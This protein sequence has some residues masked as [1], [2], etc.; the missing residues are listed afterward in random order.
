MVALDPRVPLVLL[1]CL[2]CL[3]LAVD[4][5]A[6][7]AGLAGVGVVALAGAGRG[8]P[9]LRVAAAL[10]ALVWS[11]ALS[12]GLFYGDLPRVVW[13]QLGPIVLWREG[14]VHGL[15][16]S[17][18]FVALTTAGAAVAV[19]VPP[20]R[21][22][23]GLRALRVPG[24]LAL[25]VAAAL[26]FVPQV[27]RELWWVRASRASRGRA[28]WRRWPHQWLLLELELLVPVVARSWRR[29]AALA[30]SLDSRGY[31]P[32]VARASWRPLRMRPGE[33]ALVVGAVAGT[34]VVCGVRALFWA[35]GQDLF[36]AAPLRPLYAW[37]RAW[38]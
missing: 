3:V 18:R 27:V 10:A 26:R 31:D 5:T 30:E 32:D 21:L 36:Y 23:L 2:G 6:S 20:D 19:R 15:E 16:Q 11:T 37:A 7:L 34:A 28:A 8:V 12:Q 35:Y 38:L 24:P 9:W 29:A 17:L 13:V 33:V 1:G 25:M 4:Q 22:L 14:V